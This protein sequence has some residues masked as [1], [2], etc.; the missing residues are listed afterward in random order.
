M[1]IDIEADNSDPLDYDNYVDIDW[2]LPTGMAN[3]HCSIAQDR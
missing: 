3:R 1:Y 2:P